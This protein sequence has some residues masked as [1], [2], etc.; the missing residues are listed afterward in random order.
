MRAGNVFMIQS[1]KYLSDGQLKCV[2]CCFN[3]H[4]SI[5]ITTDLCSRG[6]K[7]RFTGQNNVDCL[8]RCP[9]SP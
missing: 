4:F 7:I 2:S 1:P 9:S 6:G 5:P 3:G 8:Y